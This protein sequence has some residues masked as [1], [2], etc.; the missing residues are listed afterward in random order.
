MADIGSLVA[1]IGLA[2]MVGDYVIQSHWMAVEK[3]KCTSR[4]ARRIERDD[5]RGRRVL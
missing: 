5:F 4:F 3:T 1:S 2:H